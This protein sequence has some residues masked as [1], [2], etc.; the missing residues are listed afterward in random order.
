MRND[1]AF[2]LIKIAIKVINNTLQIAA[3]AREFRSYLNK[4]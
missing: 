2:G 3:E 1:V 4:K